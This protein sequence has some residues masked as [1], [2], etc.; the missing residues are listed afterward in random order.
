MAIRYGAF[1]TEHAEPLKALLS[2]W[3]IVSVVLLALAV[4]SLVNVEVSLKYEFE[5]VVAMG[6]E[7][8]PNVD[9]L[10]SLRSVLR[11]GAAYLVLNIVVI[12]ALFRRTFRKGH[13]S[14]AG[15]TAP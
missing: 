7:H 10:F 6:Y 1:S 9:W 8:P 2:M 4:F 14:L 3:L 12:G 5:E 13:G 11:S 15:Q